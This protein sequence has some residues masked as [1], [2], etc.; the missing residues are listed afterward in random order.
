MNPA[1]DLVHPHPSA[2]RIRPPRLPTFDAPLPTGG[3]RAEIDHRLD[4]ARMGAWV[5]VLVGASFFGGLFVLYSV[6]YASAPHVF[7]YG[8]FFLDPRTGAMETCIL[9]ASSAMAALAAQAAHAGAERHATRFVRAALALAALFVSV[10]AGEY[11]D[12]G[13]RGLLP[14]ARFTPSEAVW[15]TAQFRREHPR[16][17]EFAAHFRVTSRTRLEAMEA[18]ASPEVG[19]F[20]E[21]GVLGPRAVYPTA[22][23]QP[24]N[25]HLFF[26]LFFLM[27]GLHGALVVAAGGAWVWI[28]LARRRDPARRLDHAALDTAAL[29]WSLLAVVRVLA[30]PLLY[31]VH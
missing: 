11:S 3:A 7:A 10:Q 31:L 8:R 15:E 29:S 6:L 4:T 13:A 12:L 1:T 5:L 2:H 22:P 28:L 19:L 27:T 30:F 17:A 9:L 14:G 24:W 26:G 18:K 23:S 21:L 20:E 25:A 16:A